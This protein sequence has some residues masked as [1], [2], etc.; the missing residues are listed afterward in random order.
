MTRPRDALDAED[1]ADAELLAEAERRGYRL[2][3]RCI[4]CHRPLVSPKS[5][6]VM[7]GPTCRARAAVTA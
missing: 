1:R 3:C 5:V 7:R 2:S 6:A 4:D